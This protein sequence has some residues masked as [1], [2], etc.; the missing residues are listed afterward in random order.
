MLFGDR[1]GDADHRSNHDAEE[2]EVA[3]TVAPAAT[4]LGDDGKGAEEHVQGAVDRGQVDR[5]EKDYWFAEEEDLGAGQGGL[6]TL[7]SRDRSPFPV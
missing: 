4:L 6:E 5:D 2:G 3:D 7:L 1:V